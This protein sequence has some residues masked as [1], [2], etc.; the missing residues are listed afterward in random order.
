M[1]RGT[2]EMTWANPLLH[3]QARDPIASLNLA[4]IALCLSHTLQSLDCNLKSFLTFYLCVL[5][6]FFTFSIFYLFLMVFVLQR[7]S[8]FN[9]FSEVFCHQILCLTCLLK[10][11]FDVFLYH[12]ESVFSFVHLFVCLF[13]PGGVIAS[14]LLGHWTLET[15]CWSDTWMTWLS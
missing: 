4:K 11:I 5:S 12:L 3:S 6:F 10:Y 13:C 2:E 15:F 8:L 7:M 9:V 14:I 1:S